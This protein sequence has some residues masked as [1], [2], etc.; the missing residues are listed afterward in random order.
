VPH[1]TQICPV[2]LG[3]QVTYRF[4]GK[5]RGDVVIFH[6]P[7]A[8]NAQGI[9][10]SEV[11]IKRIVGLPGDVVS[12]HD[13]KTYVNGNLA[14][15]G[16]TNESPT[17]TMEDVLVPPGYVFVMGDNR[18]NSYDSHMW[19]PLPEKNIIGRATFRY[20]PPWKLGGLPGVED[21]QA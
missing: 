19:G 4:N 1:A 7:P 3:L 18:N 14:P 12:V 17:Y 9:P 6:A 10:Y 13:G 8:L 11:F 16:F 2:C 20:W 5:S 15:D 21:A